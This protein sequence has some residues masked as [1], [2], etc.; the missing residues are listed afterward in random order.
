MKKHVE[1]EWHSF[2]RAVM[3]IDAPAV[4]YRETRR[5]FY[6][7]ALAILQRITRLA[8]EGD[9]ITAAEEQMMDDIDQELQQF[10][11]VVRAGND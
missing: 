3:P 1:A 11:A 7:G 5:A 2:R 4:Q 8:D 6:S 9:E 10:F